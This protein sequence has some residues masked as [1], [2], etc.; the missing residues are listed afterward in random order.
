MHRF[1]A[2]GYFTTHFDHEWSLVPV[3]NLHSRLVKIIC[4]PFNQLALVG[5]SPTCMGQ[6]RKDKSCVC[7]ML[8][9]HIALSNSVFF[10]S[11]KLICVDMYE[12]ILKPKKTQN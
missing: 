10:L 2:S 5:W 8:L 12:I 3:V 7:F 6:M 11:T 1:A 9:P 4:L